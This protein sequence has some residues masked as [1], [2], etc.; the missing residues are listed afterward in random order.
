MCTTTEKRHSIVTKMPQVH[1]PNCEK[2]PS[3]CCCENVSWIWAKSSVQLECVLRGTW[4]LY[5]DNQDVNEIWGKIKTLL[6]E[7]Q[8]GNCAR[9]STR[10][11]L[12]TYLI[13]VYTNDY[14]DVQD[15]F[16]V[17]VALRR[18]HQD[19]WVMRYAVCCT[20]K[21]REKKRTTSNVIC[22]NRLAPY[23]TI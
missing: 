18:S 8:L 1:E 15:V 23:P 12:G 2:K 10:E 6:T 3:D 19:N 22:I 21:Q 16:R 7:N 4:I 9:V 17:L 13:C 5:P 11:F 20:S 14:R